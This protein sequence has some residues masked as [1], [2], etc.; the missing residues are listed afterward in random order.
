[1][2][3][4]LIEKLPEKVA[5]A[6]YREF[7]ACSYEQ[8]SV[9]RIAEMVGVTKGALYYYFD[10]KLAVLEAACD[11]AFGRF[12]VG[13]QRALQGLT[14]PIDRLVALVRF[15]VESCLEDA[16][17][18][19]FSAEIW[20]L[21]RQFPT[22]ERRWQEFYQAVFAM[23]QQEIVAAQELG[24]FQGRDPDE[25]THNLLGFYDGIKLQF[26]LGT[27][28]LISAQALVAQILDLFVYPRL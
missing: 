24:A 12:H 23:F 4:K 1:M 13:V 19:A 5:D 2:A 6:A 25:M 17:N 10:S 28:P 27:R 20:A 9:E 8:T 11:Y 26:L 22:V 15:S 3:P 18:R 7:A 14:T 16:E 21:S